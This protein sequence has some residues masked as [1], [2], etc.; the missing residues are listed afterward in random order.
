MIRVAKRKPDGFVLIVVLVLVLLMGIAAYGYTL[1]MQTENIAARVGADQAISQQAALSGIDLLSAVVEMPHEGRRELGGLQNN[2]VLFESRS[3]DEEQDA[4]D[5]EASWFTVTATS[6]SA[7]Q[8]RF[9]AIDESTKLHL[10][11]LVQWDRQRP[12]SGRDALLRLPGMTPDVSDAILDWVDTDSQPRLEG[13]ESDAYASLGAHVSPRNGKP[14]DLEELLLVRGVNEGV[15]FG[16]TTSDAGADV[17][18]QLGRTEE[19]FVPWSELLTVYSGERNDSQD[20]APRIFINDSRLAALHR[21]LVERMPV[22]WANFI[23]HLRQHGPG[24]AGEDEVTPEQV[25]L[26]FNLPGTHRIA[27]PLDLIDAKVS[28]MHN[29][30]QVSITSPFTS[31]RMMMQDQLPKLLDLVTV[32]PARRFEGRVNINLAPRVV[33]LSVPGIDEALAER[34]LSSRTVAGA[35]TTSHAHPV[36]LLTEELVDIAAMRRLL[37]NVNTGGDVFLAEFWGGFAETAPAYRCEAVIDATEGVARQ[38]YFRELQAAKQPSPEDD[39]PDLASPG[40]SAR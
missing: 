37:P 4:E 40:G 31:E 5:E 15:L 36:W 19:L 3:L 21:R 16:P 12:G 23:I 39:Q 32:S 33:L 30:E 17:V 8:Q 11:K 1:S 35:D 14:L 34:I 38:I 28:A 18:P 13:G 7:I 27:S 22:A 6:S 10:V 20:G 9:G 2:P 25:S 29:G 24:N 26:D